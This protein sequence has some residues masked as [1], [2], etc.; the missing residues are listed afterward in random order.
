MVADLPVGARVPSVE[1]GAQAVAGGGSREHEA[2]PVNDGG[3]PGAVAVESSRPFSTSFLWG[4]QRVFYERS[5]MDAWTNGTVPFYITTNT[6]MARSFAAVAA[7]YLADGHAASAIDPSSP[8]SIVELGSGTGRFAYRF[9]TQLRSRL[10]ARRLDGVKFTYVITD[11]SE[12]TLERL[13]HHDWLRPFVDDD[14]LDFAWFDAA[15]PT[16]LEL[17][18][19][20]RVVGQEAAHNPLILIANYVFDSLPQDCFRI[21]GGELKERL[22]TTWA[23]DPELDRDA[24]DFFDHVSLS[25]EDH[26]VTFPRYEDPD[27]DAVLAQLANRLGDT[28]FLMPVATANCLRHFQQASAGRLLV[29][30]ADK[31]DVS[32]VDLID[33]RDPH[34]A[35]H[36]AFSVMVNYHALGLFVSQLG[37][38]VLAP[39]HHP[40]SLATMGWLLGDRAIQARETTLAF[41]DFVARGGPDD[42]FLVKRGLEERLKSAS[43]P[44]LLAY[45]RATDWDHTIVLHAYERW[46]ELCSTTAHRLRP[47]VAH[48]LDQVWRCYFPIGE[49]L[50]LAFAIGSIL[51]AMG[52]YR[53]ALVYFERSIE[54][55]GRHPVSLQ[56]MAACA[57]S[58]RMLPSA[59]AWIEEALELDRSS[60][61]AREL[62]LLVRA[63]MGTEAVVCDL[64]SQPACDAEASPASFSHATDA[65]WA[66]EGW[67]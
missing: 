9:L 45:L 64:P 2:I 58:L 24:P 12:S 56:A 1:A 6:S 66:P 20:G 22:V 50:D 38:T 42:S 48:A 26:P 49:Q 44:E 16:D 33:T 40:E 30:T 32:E 62:R 41:A 37:G 36:G 34:L 61:G 28:T 65:A 29:L 19:S 25:F 18:K 67:S 55:Y 23:D 3:V 53:E 63:E 4:L 15:N 21:E 5:G 10:A 57:F 13:E 52:Y 35:R 11:I 59:L 27:L 17:R 7:G 39:R 54:L 46:I 47:D 60:V 14:V 43:L 31:G 51:S 8:F